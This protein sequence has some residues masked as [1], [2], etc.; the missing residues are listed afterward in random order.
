[1]D[2]S[3]I[4]LAVV[5]FATIALG[6][7]LVRW[8]HARFGTRPARPFFLSG[9]AVMLAALLASPNLLSGALGIIAVTLVWDG[10]EIY[11]QEKRMQ[12][13]KQGGGL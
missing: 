5:T 11:R 8:L 3:G 1:M 12:R 7:V 2:F 10:I 9:A 4:V 6:H 13:E